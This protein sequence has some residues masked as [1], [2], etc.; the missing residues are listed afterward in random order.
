MAD[1]Q[2]NIVLTTTG[3]D[4]AAS[5]INKAS[6]ALN[7]M[8]SASSG[9]EGQFQ[10]RFQHI[11]LMLFAGDA[12]R[13]SGLGRE[14]RLVISALNS[15]LIAG[16]TAGGLMSG[17]V[18]LVVTALVALVGIAAKVIEKHKE[19]ADVLKKLADEQDKALQGYEKEIATL[20]HLQDLDV[21]FTGNMEKLLAADK[22]VAEDMK[23]NLLATQEKEILALE[24]Q[25]DAV[26]RS[27]DIHALF[28]QGM[29]VVK[30]AL[31]TL[32]A[33]FEKVINFTK[34]LASSL[35]A[36]IPT[37]Q[38][39]VQLTGDAKLK[40]DELTAA[41]AR[42]KVQH[43]LLSK[44]SIRNL[45]D[46]EKAAED[47][48]RKEQEA[49]KKMWDARIADARAYSK[50][51]E[52]ELKKEQA[53]TER[54]AKQFSSVFQGAFKEVLFNGADFAKTFETAMVNMLENIIAEVIALITVW[55]ILDVVSGGATG[56]PVNPGSLSSFMGKNLSV[57]RH[58]TGG[59]MAVDRPTLALFGEAG[60][61]IASFSP[62]GASGQGTG[63]SGGGTTINIGT[64]ST[65]VSGVNNP[66]QIAR[67]VGQKIVEEIRGRGQISFLRA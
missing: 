35:S 2:A 55:S 36:L 26:Q 67:Q 12:L 44:D 46:L 52:E 65:S 22:A 5:E 59:S 57:G 10:H 56:S 15:A 38:K 64:I 62:M 16:E 49:Y 6:M 47:T 53:Q 27:A 48:A 11:G 32:L 23:A 29:A 19:E 18:L 14:T 42:V 66:D 13:A 60:P 37:M 54:V 24:K 61:E 40:Y 33:P 4:Q 45:Q 20:E 50:E 3:G 41:I 1:T 9:M 39:H 43:E 28:A 8:T 7:S 25:R 30:S 63:G 21:E 17:G 31:E 34:S 51:R 58:A